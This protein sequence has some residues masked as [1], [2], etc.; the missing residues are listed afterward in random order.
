MFVALYCYCGLALASLGIFVYPCASNSPFILSST[1]V[2]ADYTGVPTEPPTMG[3]ASIF[4]LC[5]ALLGAGTKRDFAAT[6]LAVLFLASL[7]SV[8]I[9]IGIGYY[10]C[11][12]VLGRGWIW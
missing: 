12:R 1:C 5:F 10:C 7:V 4:F 6:L 2:Y 3:G 8:A 9:Y 11:W